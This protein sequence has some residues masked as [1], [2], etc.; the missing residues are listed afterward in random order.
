V[1]PAA[2]HPSGQ[3][4]QP[5]SPSTHPARSPSTGGRPGGGR[6]RTSDAVERGE[7]GGLHLGDVRGRAVGQ[8]V[9]PVLQREAHAR[10]QR[11]RAARAQRAARPRS[12]LN[13]FQAPAACRVSKTLLAYGRHPALHMQQLRC[14]AGCRCVAGARRPARRARPAPRACRR[15]PDTAG[16]AGRAAWR[17]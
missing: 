4:K 8:Q 9:A 11:R 1:Q 6:A 13:V 2:P 16:A 15:R 3:H 7:H 14:D 10:R 17:T 5:A 12:R